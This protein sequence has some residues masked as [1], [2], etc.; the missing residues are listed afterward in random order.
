MNYKKKIT[1][2]KH[3]SYFL[4][5]LNA[6]NSQP[7]NNQTTKQNTHFNA[8]EIRRVGVKATSQTNI[9]FTH[10]F[11]AVTPKTRVREEPRYTV[12]FGQVMR[13]KKRG[14]E[15]CDLIFCVT[16]ARATQWQRGRSRDKTW[17]VNVR[18][19]KNNVEKDVTGQENMEENKE[20][21]VIVSLK[22][23]TKIAWKRSHGNKKSNIG[24]I[25]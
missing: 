6:N 18:A 23:G 20:C 10:L 13:V 16:T 19:G 7:T 12:R 22:K 8:Q 25:V 5:M 11:S 3:R 17:I 4:H 21:L 1:E 14:I 15:A 24:R 9:K 2:E